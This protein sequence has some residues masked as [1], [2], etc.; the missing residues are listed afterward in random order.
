[1]LK[2]FNIEGLCW[3]QPC[4]QNKHHRLRLFHTVSF[5]DK[6]RVEEIPG[7][8]SLSRRQKR[9]LWYP[10]PTQ[11]SVQMSIFH[12][13]VCGHEHNDDADEIYTGY[14]D[15]NHYSFPVAAVL[16]EQ[17]NQR[18]RGRKVDPFEIAK[19]Y[20]RCSSYSTIRAQMRAW[21]VEQDALEYLSKPARY[22][23][24]NLILRESTRKG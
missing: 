20:Q 5:A 19:V 11:A 3:S 21:E 6:V 10:N 4:L 13:L 2:L 18:G 15:K 7:R 16:T 22:R 12:Q 24:S 14:H 9:A 8:D 17:E 23:R 1:M